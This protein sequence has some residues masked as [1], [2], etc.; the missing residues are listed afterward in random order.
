MGIGLHPEPDVENTSK[1]LI[2]AEDKTSG[3]AFGL[4]RK[5]LRPSL[6]STC[7]VYGLH[8]ETLSAQERN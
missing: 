7:R 3:A 4:A 1:L 8:Q 6:L 2:C 5:P